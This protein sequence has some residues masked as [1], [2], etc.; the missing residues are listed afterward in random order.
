MCHTCI[1]IENLKKQVA[2]IRQ[3]L[4][5]TVRLFIELKEGPTRKTIYSV[6][7]AAAMLGKSAYTVSEWCRQGKLAASRSGKEGMYFITSDT[8]SNFTRKQ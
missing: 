4:T 1:E 7:E 6:K 3:E 5:E 2:S 8:I